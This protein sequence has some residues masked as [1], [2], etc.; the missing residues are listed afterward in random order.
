MMALT[1][2][3]QK[4]LFKIEQD[5]ADNKKE[6]DHLKNKASSDFAKMAIKYDLWK[7]DKKIL[8]SEFKAISD[9]HT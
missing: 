7:I 9:R 8:Q 5:I 1:A 2:A 3:E 6:L 4:K